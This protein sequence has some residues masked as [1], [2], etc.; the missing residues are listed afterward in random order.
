LPALEH[1]WNSYGNYQ[2][3]KIK[4]APGIAMVQTTKSAWRYQPTGDSQ[5]PGA[6]TDLAIE[7][8]KSIKIF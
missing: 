4:S 1:F 6:Q 3:K 5:L 8:P 2:K 7:C